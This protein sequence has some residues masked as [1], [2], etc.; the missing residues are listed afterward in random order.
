MTL[1]QIQIFL[2]VADEGGVT[3]ASKVLHKTQPAISSALAKLEAE[4][5]LTLFDR[6]GYR[7]QLSAAG[8]ALRARMARVVE[9]AAHLKA[10]AKYLSVGNEPEIRISMEVLA[11]VKPV[12]RCL[13][14]LA[15]AFPNT[16]FNLR[17]DVMQ[18]ALERLDN[19]DVDIAIGPTQGLRSGYETLHIATTQL[20]PVGPIDGLAAYTKGR[21]LAKA[22]IAKETQIVMSDTATTKPGRD[23]AV[24][25]DEKR[26]IVSNYE[27]KKQ[28]IIEGLGWGFM[29]RHLIECDLDD[30]TLRPLQIEGAN[31]RNVDIHAIR[32]ESRPR[33]PVA[34]AFWEHL[35]EAS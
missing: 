25:S 3:A 6:D 26:L 9:N 19:E 21:V 1:D 13:R 18:G 15:D 12:A 4:L 11:P 29:P 5:N 35:R 10:A 28:L 20:V 2:A 16:R 33:G 24:L 14:A 17:S 23:R 30:Q 8:H 27:E 22:D 7:L 31:V 34:D 32:L